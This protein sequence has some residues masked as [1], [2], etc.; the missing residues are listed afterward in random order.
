MARS[1]SVA[2]VAVGQMG[3]VNRELRHQRFSKRPATSRRRPAHVEH[4]GVRPEVGR[5]VAM[6]VEAPLHLKRFGTSD[7]QHLVEPAVAG[8]TADTVGNVH[9]VIEVDQ[10]S[11]LGENICDIAG[12][13]TSAH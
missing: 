12:H 3:G 10:V 9:M 11:A 1:S 13:T 4:G 7:Q 8:H 2:R 6:A 5:R